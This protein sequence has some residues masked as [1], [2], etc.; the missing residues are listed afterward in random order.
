VLP[1]SFVAPRRDGD[2][3]IHRLVACGLWHR[4]RA[5]LHVG[6]FASPTVPEGMDPWIV[7]SSTHVFSR[8]P[9]LRVDGQPVDRMVRRAPSGRHHQVR[10]AVQSE[11]GGTGVNDEDLALASGPD[12]E[13]Q[14]SPNVIRKRGVTAPVHGP[15]MFRTVVDPGPSSPHWPFEHRVARTVGFEGPPESSHLISV[16]F[17]RVPMGRSGC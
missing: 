2:E 12:A 13:L 10:H 6:V 11:P 9:G 7:S 1:G 15:F 3:A 4:G 17:P 14:V 16:D 8:Q 5:K